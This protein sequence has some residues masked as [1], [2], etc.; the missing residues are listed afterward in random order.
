MIR[1]IVILTFVCVT[2]FAAE[3]P[4]AP[5]ARS[6]A[7]VSAI[8]AKAAP[9]IPIEKLRPL[10]ILLLA[11][12]KDHGVGEHD[13]P[14]WQKNWTPLIS[15]LP[16]VTVD[17]AFDW[18]TP[19]QLNAADLVVCFLHPPWTDKQIEAM[20]AVF[21]RGGG[22]VL[23]HWAVGAKALP[24]KFAERFGLAYTSGAY[25]HGPLELKLTTAADHPITRGF[26]S[27]LS[28]LDE[29]YWPM[30][31]DEAKVT[32]LATSEEFAV[33]GSPAK[34][35]FPQVWTKEHAKGRAFCMVPG[36]YNWSFNDPLFRLLLLRG[37]A[38]AAG[39]EAQRFDTLA[40]D[41]VIMK[42]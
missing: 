18:P 30:V 10:K 7:E 36:H 39:D 13:Y 22:V 6:K 33:K 12:K 17:T 40:T 38:W 21:A 29:A 8:L 24:D 32:V 11:G 2:V 31:G 34:K 26:P 28:F 37:M 5:E 20:D 3:L 42:E 35:S 19:E 4:P 23:I 16:K 27:P 25:R 9:A 1:F 41:G 15:K 14:L